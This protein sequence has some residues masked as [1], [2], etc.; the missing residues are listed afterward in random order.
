MKFKVGEVVT[1]KHYSG[2]K[3]NKGLI[4]NSHDNSLIVKPDKDFL[5]YSYFDN[6]PIVLGYENEELINICEGVITF[7]N[8]KENSFGLTVNNMQSITNKRITQRFPVSLCAYITHRNTRN[9]AYMRNIS[10]DGLSLCTKHEFDK[11]EIFTIHT[12]I[13]TIDLIFDARV[14]WKKTSIVGNEYGLEFHSVE[15]K[16]AEKIENCINLLRIEQ[17]N[18]IGRLKYEFESYKKILQSKAVMN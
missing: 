16:F 17:E 6:D 10:L 11:G 9:F 4:S 1:L 8:Y 7:L 5:V 18:A 14:I 3:I 2:K 13:E 12:S 15:E